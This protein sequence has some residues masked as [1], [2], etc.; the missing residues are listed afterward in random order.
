MDP[1]RRNGQVFQRN[2]LLPVHRQVLDERLG[3][4]LVRGSTRQ[5]GWLVDRV[6][7]VGEFGRF[8]SDLRQICELFSGP[9][10]GNPQ[11]MKRLDL[12]VAFCVI[13]G[14]EGGFDPTEQTQP[15]DAADD[16]RMGMPATKS[17]F[18]IEL[19]HQWQA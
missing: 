11:T 13:H 8:A 4:H 9:E 3:A 19:L 2:Q 17:R 12:V 5:R 7:P 6:I 15:D 18:I 1:A 14:R 10:G 16:M